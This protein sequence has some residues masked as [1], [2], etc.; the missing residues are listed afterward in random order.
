[1]NLTLFVLLQLL[2]YGALAVLS[3]IH[4]R[5]GDWLKCVVYLVMAGLLCLKASGGQI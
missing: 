4:C 1:M 3:V 2:C 5:N